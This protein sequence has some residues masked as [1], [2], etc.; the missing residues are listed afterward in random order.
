MEAPL[1]KGCDKRKSISIFGEFLALS[2]TV[3]PARAIDNWT[4]NM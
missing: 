4:L 3:Q 2:I 1:E